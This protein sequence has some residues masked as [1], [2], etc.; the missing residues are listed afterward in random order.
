MTRR[1][2]AFLLLFALTSP[3]L[4]R[5]VVRI[6]TK[7]DTE[8]PIL[9]H[10]MAILA[11]DAGATA[12][13]RLVG[14]SGLIWTALTSGQ[15]DAYVDYTGTLRGDTLKSLNLQSDDDLRKALAERGVGMSR[16]IGFNN[17]YGL[18]VARALADK[19]KLSKVSDLVAHPELRVGVSNEWAGRADGWPSVKNAY[20]LPQSDVTAVDHELLY[21]AINAGQ[22]D[23][24]EVYTTDGKIPVYDIV[25]LADD[26]G[27]FPEYEAVM[28]W[29]KELEQ[30]QPNVVAAWRK[31]EGAIDEKAIVAMNKRVAVD[32]AADTTVAADFARERFGDAAAA[33]G[34]V[35]ESRSHRLLRTTGQHLLLVGVSMLLGILAAI[36]LGV[37]A[38]KDRTIGRAVLP[39]VGA[40]Q[41]VPS[42][43]LLAFMITVPLLGLGTRSAIA[44]LFLY[45]LLPMVRNT[46]A[47]LTGISG[48][49]RESAQALGLTWWQRLTRVELPLALPSILAGIKTSAVITVGFATLGAFIG[50]G[51]YGEQ[52]LTGLRLLDNGL[53]LEGAIASAVLAL[54]VQFG[55][56]AVTRLAVPRV[57]RQ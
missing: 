12:D 11:R 40:I 7:N 17:T 31:L 51:G 15:I 50:A 26:R 28:L 57:L 5:D 43:A 1:I 45:S 24:I 16:P 42:L 27:F 21:G 18:G 34:D 22:L 52:I 54:L 36:P 33:L 6:G 10:V 55:L 32:H 53:I 3:A 56:D 47:G 38:A 37:W 14:G 8:T 29:R 46:H 39:I 2:I 44:A 4:A 41:T 48:P 19:L 13:V 30:K 25:V 49:V 20:G 9:G 23:V 35:A